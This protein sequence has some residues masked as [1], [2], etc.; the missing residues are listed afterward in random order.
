MTDGTLEFAEKAGLFFED[1]GYPRIAGRIFGLLLMSEGPRSLNDIAARLRV[2]KAS[3]STDARLLERWDI[4]E[5]VSRPGDRKVYYRI[6][7]DLPYRIMEH[8]VERVRRMGRLMREARAAV[9]RGGV[10]KARLSEFAAAYD[11]ALV[12]MEKAL[13]RVSQ[14]VFASNGGSSSSE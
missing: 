14:A 6:V 7:P 4:V 8:R 5:R 3:V 1:D 11:Q 9:P 12:T 2:S 10:L 13:R